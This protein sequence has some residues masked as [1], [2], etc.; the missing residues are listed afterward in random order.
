MVK[1]DKY[2]LNELNG[3]LVFVVKQMSVVATH[4]TAKLGDP[5]SLEKVMADPSSY[6]L[7]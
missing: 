4:L 7:D 5:A 1:V 6:K 2:L 3:K